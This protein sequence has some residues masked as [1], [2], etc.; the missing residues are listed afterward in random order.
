MKQKDLALLLVIAFLSAVISFIV[1]S[2]IFAPPTARQQAVENVP[3]ISTDFPTPDTKYFNNQ[4]IDPTQ[5]I[6]IGGNNNQ[7]PF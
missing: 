7:N 5:L 6:Q 2:K 3:S 4:S 1:S